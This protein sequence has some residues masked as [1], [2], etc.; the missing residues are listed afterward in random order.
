MSA[1]GPG[2]SNSKD[3]DSLCSGSPRSSLSDRHN[4][5]EEEE[6]KEKHEDFEHATNKAG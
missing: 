1:S 3:V 2:D 4:T 5:T 6:S